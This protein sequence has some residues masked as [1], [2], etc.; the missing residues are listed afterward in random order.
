MHWGNI[1]YA[2]VGPA[3]WPGQQR[4][5]AQKGGVPSGTVMVVPSWNRPCGVGEYA[6]SLVQA[7]RDL[8]QQVEVVTQTFPLAEHL[9]NPERVHLQYEYSLH[10]PVRV[11]EL[12]KHL[13]RR[14]VNAVVTLHSFMP[15]LSDHNSLIRACS[16]I[17]VH[18]EQVRAGLLALGTDPERI[19]LIPIPVPCYYLPDQA[20]LR[21]ELDLDGGPLLGFFGFAYPHKGM[22]TLADAVQELRWRFPDLRAYFFTSAAPNETSRRC[23]AEFLAHVQGKKLQGVEVREG[24]LT[25]V[26]TVC[27]LAAMDLS[28]LPYTEHSAWATSAAVRMALAAGRPIVATNTSFFSDLEGE[29]LKLPA[30][31]V[32]SIVSGV[33]WLLENPQEQEALARR[34]ASYCSQNTWEIAAARHIATYMR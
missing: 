7:L 14:N 22:I 6:H 26:E 24:Y 11:G 33:T 31:D 1:T 2:R 3:P 13:H 34:A 9:A 30:G 4:T 16:R 5:P 25:E 23:L 32:G 8:G 18:S 21:R 10:D 28:V 29:V 19:E 15:G 27:R 20:V 12:L 17:I